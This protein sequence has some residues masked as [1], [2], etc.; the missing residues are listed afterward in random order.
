MLCYAACPVVGLEEEFTGP[1]AIALAQ[2]YN[3]RTRGIRARPGPADGGARRLH[4]GM[5]GCTL[6]IGECTKVCPKNVDPAGA[7]QLYK[8]GQRDELVQ[9]HAPAVGFEV[10]A[11]ART[12][13]AGSEQMYRTP[14]A[15]GLVA[16]ERRVLQAFV[17]REL[18]SVFVGLFAVLSLWQIRALPARVG[19]SRMRGVR[20]APGRA[21]ESSL[22]QR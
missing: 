18:T 9:V 4:D 5:W 19:R 17:V 14:D 2:R 7:I 15:A 1:A 13:P 16:A 6:Q 12:T 11:V 20:G 22:S 8:D 21:G 3:L 10:S